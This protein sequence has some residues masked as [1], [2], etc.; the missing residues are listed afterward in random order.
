MQRM[1][2]I[3]CVLLLVTV[4]V[5]Y[6]QAQIGEIPHQNISLLEPKRPLWEYVSGGAFIL[7]VLAL[8]FMSSRRIKD[9]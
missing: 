6:G 7:A 1:I 9:S 8:G 3:V 4:S 2:Q 5:A